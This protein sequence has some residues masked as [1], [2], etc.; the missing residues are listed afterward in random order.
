[1]I[2]LLFVI[3]APEAQEDHFPM[4]YI[5]LNPSSSEEFEAMF[6]HLPPQFYVIKMEL[7]K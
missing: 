4:K 5:D 7:H 1:M 3:Q 2:N 6:Y